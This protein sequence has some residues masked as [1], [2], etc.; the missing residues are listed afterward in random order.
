[1]KP[2]V[3]H[4]NQIKQVTSGMCHVSIKKSRHNSPKKTLALTVICLFFVQLFFAQEENGLVS[5]SL[6]VRNSLT[7]NRHI[8]NPAFSFVREQ[9][10]YIS[11]FNKQEWVQ[12][13][14]APQTYVLGYSGRLAEN[15]GAGL[16]LFQQ[17]YG[18]L[19]TFGGLLN[20]AYNVRLKTDSNFTFGL[21][22]GV[23]KSGLNTGKVITNFSDPSLNNSPSHLLLTVNPGINYGTVFMDFGVSI[24]NVVLYNVQSSELIQD[25]PRQTIQAHIMYT[26]YMH[27]RGFFDQAKFSGLLKSEFRKEA[28]TVSGILMLTSPKGIW[29]QVGFNSLYG[30]SAGLGLNIT[31]QIAIEYN[32]EK[33]LGEMTNFGTSHDITLAY[34]FNNKS[35]YQYNDDDEMRGVFSSDGKRVLAS[36]RPKMDKNTRAQLAQEAVDRRTKAQ[37]KAQARAEFAAEERATKAK[38]ASEVKATLQ[39]EEK[40]TLAA[41]AKT[42]ADHVVQDMLAVQEKAKVE[43][44]AKLFAAAKAKANQKVQDMLAVQEKAK[45]E[46]NAKLVAAAKAKADQEVEDMLAVQEKAIAE[47]NA[48]LVAEAKVKADQDVQD[49]LAIQEKAKAEA[50]SK[51]VAEAK[52]KADQDVQD[53]LAV[54]EKAKAVAIADA[55]T[56]SKLRAEEKAKQLADGEAAAIVVVQSKQ[57]KTLETPTDAIGISMKSVADL[58]ETSKNMQDE[59]LSRFNAVVDSKNK[60]LQDLKE[61]NDLSEQG[62]YRAPKAFKSITEENNKLEVISTDLN[63]IIKINN[64]R[65]EELEKLYKARFK[66][67]TLQNDE[68]TLYYQKAL[69]SLKAEQLKAIHTRTELSETL[70]RINEETEFER[71]RR[72]KRAAYTS[73]EDRYLQD[74]AMLKLIKQRTILSSVALKTEDFDFGENQGNNIQIIKNVD[75]VEDGYYIVVAVHTDVAKRDVFI[76][77]AIAS[78]QSNIDFFYDVNTSKYFIYY[79]ID[80][81]VDEAMETF[82]MKG[83]Q[84]YNSQMSI[85]KIEN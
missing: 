68:V 23:Y 19:T 67:P 85:L 60:V 2:L 1:M 73:E 14:H 65:I 7:F 70:K 33:A 54:Q 32:F 13:D 72:I 43:A 5:L 77:K 16:S 53:K 27:G 9:N 81:S 21:N 83:S 57:E 59:L 64:D 76:T 71:K 84:P 79:K 58:T 8:I 80:D 75:N 46:A 47:A 15:I 56:Q 31:E 26:G 48:K 41:N 78:G 4:I 11:A 66:I 69:Q 3:L 35:N 28:T 34:K 45:A 55:K 22:L 10:K 39:V 40:D 63:T 42:K 17:D 12:F 36:N 25:D 61:E 44:N 20:F 50:S 6:P 52:V 62:I 49:M 38:L 24:N 29:T 37:E 30:G 74:R 51:L 18:M 82:K